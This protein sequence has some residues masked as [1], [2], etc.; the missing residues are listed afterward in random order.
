MSYVTS[1]ADK[2]RRDQIIGAQAGLS[3][4]APESFGG[5]EAPRAIL[6]KRHRYFRGKLVRNTIR[7]RTE[8]MPTNLLFLDTP[9]WRT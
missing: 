9:K 4:H 3:D 2:E 8:I 1:F 7:S 5:S 6:G